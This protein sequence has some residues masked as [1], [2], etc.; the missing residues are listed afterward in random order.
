MYWCRLATV[1]D[2]DEINR[3]NYETFVEEIPQH[4][5]NEERKLVDK[6]HAKNTYLL[7]LKETAVIGMVAF[8]DE[9]P[10]SLD[11]K[12]GKVEQFLAPGSSK[13]IC[14][15]RLLIIQKQYRNGR[16]LMCLMK[17]LYALFYERGYT[18]AV[19][20][21]TVREEKLYKGI[22]FTQ[23]APAVGSDDA[24]YLPMVISKKSIDAFRARV[25]KKRKNFYPGPV[26]QL[27]SIESSPISHRS[28]DGVAL[29]N[30]CQQQLTKLS[31][32]RYVA[33]L[34]G[35]GTTANDMML[36]TI[37]AKFPDEPG[38][39][40][41]NGEFGKRLVQQAVCWQLNFTDITYEPDQPFNL[42]QIEEMFKQVSWCVFVHGETSTGTRNPLELLLKHAKVY[43][44]ALCVDCISTFGAMPFSLKEVYIAT[45]TSGKAVGALAG[46]GFV[47][48]NEKPV[49]AN[50][51]HYANLALFDE[52]IPF[53]LPIYLLS[54]SLNALRQYPAR[55]ELLQRRQQKL[56]QSP[57][58]EDI[59]IRT[60][61]YPMIVSFHA[62][63][64]VQCANVN[65]FDLHAASRY[66]K[67]RDIVQIS[68]IQPHFERDFE[69]LQDLYEQY[70]LSCKEHSSI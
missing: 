10:F 40:I 19:I 28:V 6:F 51:P 37:K 29:F 50:M 34:N 17:A 56:L 4:E 18:S 63:D 67:E 42:E 14:E 62:T 24:L 1:K 58:Y 64:F 3:L 21:G 33:I 61:H 46:L 16:A 59:G 5:P 47:F 54:N 32:S 26:E 66:L 70:K 12:I 48:Y 31:E 27:T 23:F 38:V 9:R 35:S 13:K 57:I 49:Q 39:I 55:F 43:D 15:L 45:A 11:Q 25:L 52:Q 65:D 60:A 41:S 44:V 2:E 7:V 53:T 22:G 69:A 8:R 30:E 36:A 68:I 20:S